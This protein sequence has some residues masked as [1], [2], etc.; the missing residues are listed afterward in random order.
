MLTCACG[1]GMVAPVVTRAAAKKLR[2]C[3]VICMFVLIF[4]HLGVCIGVKRTGTLC[5]LKPQLCNE[6]P[7]SHFPKAAITINAK[8]ET[9]CVGLEA[10]KSYSS[11]W[12][13]G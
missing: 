3:P 8:H 12:A 9:K 5:R 4:R 6:A 11:T 10:A 1:N 7:T 2:R 13:E